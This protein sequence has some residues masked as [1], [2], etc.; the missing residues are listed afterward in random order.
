VTDPGSVGGALARSRD[1]LGAAGYADPAREADEIYAA[2]VQG[3]VSA[4]WQAREERIPAARLAALR[5]AVR[6]RVAGWP[7][8]YAT[9]WAAFRGQWLEV[10]RRVLIPRPET[11]GLVELVMEWVRGCAGAPVPRHAGTAADV[12]TGS[13]A[14][15]LALALEGPF[16]RVWAIER[17]PD[18]LAVARGNVRRLG[19]A[20]RVRAVQGDLLEPLAGR[21]VDVVVSNPPYIATAELAELDA[22]VRDFEPVPALDGGADGL[23]PTRRL[24]EAARRTLAPGGLIALEVDSRRATE[25]AV[26]VE[27]AGFPAVAIAYDLFHRP[28]YVWAEHPGA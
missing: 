24:A 22:S 13:G 1:E 6:R 16:D 12:G 25:T 7:Q 28:R 23:G 15:A 8:A 14:I 2:L 26:A 4:A 11:E 10:D 21:Q 20:G 3:P 19:V 27:A 5:E 18:A 9:G 17:S